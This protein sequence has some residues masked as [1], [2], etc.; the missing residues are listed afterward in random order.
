MIKIVEWLN[1]L[2]EL[3]FD[4]SKG[5][6]Y[7]PT[8]GIQMMGNFFQKTRLFKLAFLLEKCKI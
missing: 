7:S 3:E 8:L 4:F 1:R 5:E 6:V 2:G